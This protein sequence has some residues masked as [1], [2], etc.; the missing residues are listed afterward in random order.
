M[1]EKKKGDAGGG[2]KNGDRGGS[3]RG[4][5]KRGG[6]DRSV[7][8]EKEGDNYNNA[9]SWENHDF[10][11]GGKEGEEWGNDERY[12]GEND[13]GESEEEEEKG[14]GDGSWM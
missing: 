2:K 1:E 4:K 9:D 8:K 3:K 7:L 5:K 6:I 10:D 14:K 11:V 13:N 12:K